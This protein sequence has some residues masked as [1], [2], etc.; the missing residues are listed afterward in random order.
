MKR[1]GAVG[2]A[3]AVLALATGAVLG[4]TVIGL[5]IED[6]ARLSRF[7]VAGTIVGQHGV[8]DPVNGL[9]TE[10]T[11]L[12]GTVLKGEA[13][14]GER[15]VFHT[16][17][18]ELYGER[19]MAVGE[20]EFHAGQKALVFIEEVDG[21]LY[22]LGLSMGVWSVG[23]DTRGHATYARA[24]TDGL[25][26]VGDVAIEQGPIPAAAMKARV[27][28]AIEHPAFDH[29]LLRERVAMER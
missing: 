25:E 3:C 1:I 15:I 14:R 28:N 4:S 5:S 19:S 20:A 8:D 21:R 6:Q 12:V 18:G 27:R 16:R 7:V 23:A 2:A 13:R 10:V 26:I 9:E 17:S 22:N 11:L 24:L 29:P